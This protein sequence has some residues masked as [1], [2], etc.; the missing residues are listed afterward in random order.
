MTTKRNTKKVTKKISVSLTER[1][2]ALLQRYATASGISKPA[3][4]RKVLKNFLCQFEK[5]CAQDATKNQLNLFD[6]M[7]ID[8]FNNTSKTE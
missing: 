4:I 1:E 8:I 3:V 2:T 7:Q 5:G 6:S